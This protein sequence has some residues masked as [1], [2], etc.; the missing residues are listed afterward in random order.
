VLS[1][2]DAQPLFLGHRASIATHDLTGDMQLHSILDERSNPLGDPIGESKLA[3]MSNGV[4]LGD[5][6]PSN[7]NNTA[8]RI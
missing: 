5:M 7:I 2:T 3:I 4:K 6:F 8:D 1:I